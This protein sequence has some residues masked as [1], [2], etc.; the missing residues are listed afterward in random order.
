MHVNI[1]KGYVRMGNSRIK[2]HN[3]GSGVD[4]KHTMLNIWSFLGFLHIYMVYPSSGL[5]LLSSHEN[6]VCT[7]SRN[8][9]CCQRL[10]GAKAWLRAVVGIVTIF[11][12]V[13]TFLVKLGLCSIWASQSSLYILISS[14]RSLEIAGPLNHLRC[15]VV[16]PCPI[17]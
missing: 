5:V 7:M 16:K 17:D 14:S 13:A 6:R 4:E 8:G 2:R 9:I 3:Y 15:G 1:C 10:I 11:S 12:T